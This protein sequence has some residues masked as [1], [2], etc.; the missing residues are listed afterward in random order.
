MSKPGDNLIADDGT[1]CVIVPVKDYERLLEAAESDDMIVRC[2][3][4][5][6]W[7]DRDDE[8]C[9]SGVMEFHGLLES[10]ERTRAGFASVP[11]LPSARTRQP[12][13]LRC[14]G[15]DHARGFC[16]LAR[17]ARPRL[18]SPTLQVALQGNQPPLLVRD[19]LPY[20]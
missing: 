17:S 3:Q 16:G 19:L 1:P 11:L 2:E 20:R 6:A 9:A 15:P 13:I 12:P 8:A 18:V 4:C 14:V 10:G 5:N 7:L